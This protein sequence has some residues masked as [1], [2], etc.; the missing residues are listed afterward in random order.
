MEAKV[1]KLSEETLGPHVLRAAIEMVG[2]KI[3]E[4]RTVFEHVV[5]GREQ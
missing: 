1:C 4:L 5:D 3:L 2:T